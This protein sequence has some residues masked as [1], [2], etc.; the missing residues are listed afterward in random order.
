MNV[1]KLT[2]EFASGKY[3]IKAGQLVCFGCDP[4]LKEQCSD[5]EPHRGCCSAATL[6]SHRQRG[7]H[8][9]WKREGGREGGG[10]ER[11]NV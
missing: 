4:S 6:S 7:E 10:G 9:R 8:R 3:K 2:Y 1:W 5:A 11:R